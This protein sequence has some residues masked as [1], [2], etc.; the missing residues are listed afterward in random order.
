MC[1][2]LCFDVSKSELKKAIREGHDSIEKLSEHIQVGSHCGGCIGHV[3]EILEKK[4][5]SFLW[6][7][8]KIS[9]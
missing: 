8:W 9:N 5:R 3:E 7:R 2:C 6:Q 1:I 4:N